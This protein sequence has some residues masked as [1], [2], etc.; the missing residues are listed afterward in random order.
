MPFRVRLALVT[1]VL[2]L[3]G[4]LCAAQAQPPQACPPGSPPDETVKGLIAQSR[5]QIREFS[6]AG[7]KPDD[8]AHPA[9]RWSRT[10]WQCREAYP[11]TPA[12]T[13]AT[14]EAVHI[15]IHAASAAQ[16]LDLAGSV[17]PD[18]A[19]WKRLLNFVFEAAEEGNHFRGC[20]RLVES[21]L[22]H[23]QDS[24]L[25]A[26]GRMT[27]A[28]AHRRLGETEQ[29][30]ALFERVQREA[31]GTPL[32]DRAAGALRQLRE[33]NPGQPAPDFSAQARDG[34]PVSLAGFRDRAVVLIFWS[35]T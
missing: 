13:E 5:Q 1:L 17:P 2:A 27:L 3:T 22:P 21:L 10:F 7:G 8:P 25:K 32:A 34:S 29:A 31:A 20:I 11:G 4:E 18:D 26:Q 30:A 19:A 16:A 6:Q 28:H 24:E 35:T 23:W 15:L 12:A 33:L 9:L 14:A